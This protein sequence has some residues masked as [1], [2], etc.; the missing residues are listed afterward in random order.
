MRILCVCMGNRT[1]YVKD[2]AVWA[3]AKE[4][5]GKDGLSGV[6]ETALREYVEQK[7]LEKLGFEARRFFIQNGLVPEGRF[8]RF[9]GRLLFETAVGT[10]LGH[11]PDV[12]QI[13][14][15]KAGKIVAV[16]NDGP[17]GEP[18][19]YYVYESLDDFAHDKGFLPDVPPDAREEV[20]EAVAEALGQKNWSVWID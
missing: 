13:F 11:P 12:A 8:V 16:I 2:D 3:E 18:E 5:A 10:E 19:E 1:I 15:T 14:Q 9:N 17:S 6:I 4:I 7:R 20:R